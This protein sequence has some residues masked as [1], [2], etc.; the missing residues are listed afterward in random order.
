MQ[1]RTILNASCHLFALP[2]GYVC[3]SSKGF[4]VVERHWHVK[5]PICTLQPTDEQQQQERKYQSHASHSL[6][7]CMSEVLRIPTGGEDFAPVPEI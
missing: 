5:S 4:A 2:G 1:W 3:R 7:G 6:S